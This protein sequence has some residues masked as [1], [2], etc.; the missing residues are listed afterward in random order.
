MCVCLCG[1]GGVVVV[2]GMEVVVLMVVM[3]VMVLGGDA[4][5]A[6]HSSSLHSMIMRFRLPS[7]CR[8]HLLV[9]VRSVPNHSRSLR[10]HN[11]G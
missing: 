1:G 6:A 8:R 2:E 9:R 4:F 11:M 7:C 3:V 5:M 10:V